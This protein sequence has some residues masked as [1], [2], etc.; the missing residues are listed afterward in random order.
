M[1]AIANAKPIQGAQ[2]PAGKDGADGKDA[3]TPQ[4]DELRK[5][6]ADQRQILANLKGVFRVRIEPKR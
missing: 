6:L 3:V 5:E 2:G 4:I 1:D